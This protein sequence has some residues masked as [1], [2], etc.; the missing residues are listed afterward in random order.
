M[1]TEKYDSLLLAHQDLI[2]GGILEI[3]KIQ[4]PEEILPKVVERM[5]KVN[6]QINGV[7]VH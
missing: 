1:T 3:V 2:T 6:E 5:L 7:A 4:I